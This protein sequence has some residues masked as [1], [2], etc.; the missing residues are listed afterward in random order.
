MTGY[1]IDTNVLVN[2]NGGSSNPKETSFPH[3]DC[4]ESAS[5]FLKKIRNNHVILLDSE[6][7]ILEEYQ[8]R[9][10]KSYQ[11]PP[12]SW[13]LLEM[14]SGRLTHVLQEIYL[15]KDVYGHYVDLHQA[16]I[17]SKFDQD[18][19]KFAALAKKGNAPVAVTTDSDW[20]DHHPL[21]TQHGIAIEFLCGCDQSNWWAAAS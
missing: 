16:I 20:L 8:K 18:D 12:G 9:V 7:L 13:F 21:L 2:A 19:R 17:S 4:E 11:S 3:P 14:L 5:E 1:V 15:E 10:D 6:G